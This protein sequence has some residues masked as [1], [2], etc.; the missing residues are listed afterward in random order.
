MKKSELAGLVYS[1]SM[2]AQVEHATGEV[3][4][5][6][7]SNIMSLLFNTDPKECR[8][9][10]EQLNEQLTAER[11]EEAITTY[12]TKRDTMTKKIIASLGDRDALIFDPEEDSTASSDVKVD[13]APP[14]EG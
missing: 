1:A 14:S 2:S 10:L 3:L 5:E 13:P 6:S 9:I 12:D 4:A 11:L 7:V 8:S